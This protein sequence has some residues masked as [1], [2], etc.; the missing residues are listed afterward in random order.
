[1]EGKFAGV[2]IK[3]II[4]E[5]E[6][7][8]QPGSFLLTGNTKPIKGQIR[9]LG[10]RWDSSKMAWVFMM[11]HKK[12]LIQFLEG[13]LEIN[14][15]VRGGKVKTKKNGIM[16]KAEALTVEMMEE[17]NRDNKFIRQEISDMR[18]EIKEKNKVIIAKMGN[19]EKAINALFKLF[20]EP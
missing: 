15:T 4:E 16:T 20:S 3:D 2:T 5:N 13:S 7:G 9:T 12:R 14:P 10:G 18:E 19:L 17:I 1:M 6:M 8:G 11:S